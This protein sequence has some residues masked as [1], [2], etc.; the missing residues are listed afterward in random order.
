MLFLIQ[1]CDHGMYFLNNSGYCY[2]YYEV[3]DLYQFG[4][5]HHRS[6]KAKRG[7]S[8]NHLYLPFLSGNSNE[9]GMYVFFSCKSY[10]HF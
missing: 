7:T 2:K 4:L 6:S 8:W 10:I 5:L 1:I 3:K 9:F